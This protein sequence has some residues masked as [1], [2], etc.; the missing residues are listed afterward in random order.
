MDLASP[1]ET[2]KPMFRIGED[3]GKAVRDALLASAALPREIVES[4]INKK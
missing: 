1:P 2:H 3:A 4:A